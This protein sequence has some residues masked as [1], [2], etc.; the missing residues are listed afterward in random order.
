M[1]VTW[2]IVIAHTSALR[3]AVHPMTSELHI[4]VQVMCLLDT[5]CLSIYIWRSIIRA[6]FLVPPI[7]QKHFFR[8]SAT[9]QYTLMIYVCT[10]LA[11]YYWLRLIGM[12]CEHC[13]RNELYLQLIGI[14]FTFL[15]GVYYAYWS[16]T[17]IFINWIYA[18][19]K[20]RVNYSQLIVMKSVY[21]RLLRSRNN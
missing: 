4:V 10:N 2:P 8:C 3:L 21:N 19:K 20:T 11:S 16:L 17:C 9:T 14:H 18:R 15:T 13:N 6:M 1:F 7:P 12:D 5:I